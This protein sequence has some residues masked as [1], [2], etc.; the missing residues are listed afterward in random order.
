MP[1]EEYTQNPALR[2]TILVHE[3]LKNVY[4]PTP[5]DLPSTRPDANEN[6]VARGTP[7][8]A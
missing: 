6:R 4:R 2:P 1:I 5:R 8:A 7:R 3:V